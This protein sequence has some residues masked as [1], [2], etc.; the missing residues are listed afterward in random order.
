MSDSSMTLR[1][2]LA[3]IGLVTLLGCLSASDEHA[4]HHD[5]PH[6]PADFVAA[7]ERLQVIQTASSTSEEIPSP[8]PDG[9]LQLEAADLL[10]WLP[11]LAAESDLSREDWNQ[12]YQSTAMIRRQAAQVSLTELSQ[13]LASVLPELDRCANSI[14]SQRLALQPLDASE[15]NLLEED[16]QS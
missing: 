10:R 2:L 4:E 7:V 14:R 6:R 9:D 3:A 12:M 5:P 13:A 16:N 15:S 8:H 11:E 1:R